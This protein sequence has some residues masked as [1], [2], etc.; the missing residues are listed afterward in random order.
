MICH[1][2]PIIYN[3]TC[4]YV[5]IKTVKS[6]CVMCVYVCVGQ[7]RARSRGWQLRYVLTH[8]ANLDRN[9][10]IQGGKEI[11][12]TTIYMPAKRLI[13][14]RYERYSCHFYCSGNPTTNLQQL[15]PHTVLY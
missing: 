8:T 12:Y 7:E 5:R 2:L 6:V 9:C 4:T 10:Q 11:I 14:S 15:L 13:L 1:A 3:S